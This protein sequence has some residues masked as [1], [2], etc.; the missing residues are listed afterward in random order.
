M[1]QVHIVPKDATMTILNAT[2]AFLRDF[3]FTWILIPG[4]MGEILKFREAC[5]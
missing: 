1:L 3:D 5:E 2:G 4:I